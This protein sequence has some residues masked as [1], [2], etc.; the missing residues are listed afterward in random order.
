MASQIKVQVLAIGELESGSRNGRDWNRR[1]LQIFTGEV[2]GNH[3]Y[4]A[5]KEKLQDLQAGFYMIGIAARAGD[6]GR[7]E[8]AIGD[9]SPVS[10]IKAKAS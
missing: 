7:L 10:D 5:D 4:Y 3:P 1:T 6:R 2:A 8:F 9:M